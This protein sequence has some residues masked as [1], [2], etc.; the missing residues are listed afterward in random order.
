[1]EYQLFLLL[2]I[3]FVES[4]QA[5]MLNRAFLQPMA[6]HQILKLHLEIYLLKIILEHGIQTTYVNFPEATILHS[7][8]EISI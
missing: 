2:Q 4:R 7:S 8:K 5:P 1:M 3:G 6:G